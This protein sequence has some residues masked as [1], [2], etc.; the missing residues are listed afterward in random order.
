MEVERV[1]A[2]EFVDDGG[3]VVVVTPV[4][5]YDGGHLQSPPPLADSV[6]VGDM[7][8]LWS[9]RGRLVAFRLSG[10]GPVVAADLPTA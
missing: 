4:I 6:R 3:H 2:Q 5:G 9:R 1:G 10:H 8:E 7:I